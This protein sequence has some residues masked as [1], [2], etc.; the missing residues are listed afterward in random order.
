MPD[1]HRPRPAGVKKPDKPKKV[2]RRISKSGS[3]EAEQPNT[4]PPMQIPSGPLDLK[5]SS[6]RRSHMPTL[7]SH[8]VDMIIDLPM[9]DTPMIVKNKDMRNGGGRRRSSLGL[10][11]KRVSTT[12]NGLCQPPHMTIDPADFYRH[13]DVD[14]SD[15]VRMRQLLVWCG[16][17][18]LGESGSAGRENANDAD[19][20]FRK[21][22]E[23]IIDRLIRKEINTS[24]Y[25]RPPTPASEPEDAAKKLP[26]PQNEEN[27]RKVAELEVA[28]ERLREEDQKWN[29]MLKEQQSLDAKS[30]NQLDAIRSGGPLDFS[31]E[32][33][34][35]K[36]YITEEQ[37]GTID[38]RCDPFVTTEIDAW[39][40]ETVDA[41]RTEIDHTEHVLRGAA[42]SERKTQRFCDDLFGRM[43]RAYDE[44]EKKEKVADPMD[45]LRL[46]ST[47]PAIA[48]SNGET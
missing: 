3:R 24:W 22:Q 6:S 27:A 32:P 37:S 42:A 14:Q 15:P 1:V 16:Q 11:G 47:A 39:T 43:L 48:R 45:I 30:V 28:L 34:N 2:V 33:D 40:G 12:N 5:V 18:I 26:H 35:L 17:R 31:A 25:H 8:H 21:V 9:S 20:A 4:R 7:A 19:N 23:E 10:R 44:K 46:L 41:I 36:S 38:A 29:S 13:I